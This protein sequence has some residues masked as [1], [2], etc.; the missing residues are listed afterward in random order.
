MLKFDLANKLL[1]KHWNAALTRRNPSVKILSGLAFLLVSILFIGC[2]RNLDCC[3]E[4][5]FQVNSQSV[6][7]S[8]EVFFPKTNLDTSSAPKIIFATPSPEPLGDNGIQWFDAVDFTNASVLHVWFAQPKT[9]FN[10]YS[11]SFQ[12]DSNL[13]KINFSVSYS[14]KCQGYCTDSSFPL[15]VDG[16]VYIKIPKVDS[17]YGVNF[18]QFFP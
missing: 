3:N 14:D 11:F 15:P 4:P 8:S 5:Q 13:K 7:T 17:S 2:K 18:Q 9:Y 6:Q 1:V 16:S 12:M 10:S